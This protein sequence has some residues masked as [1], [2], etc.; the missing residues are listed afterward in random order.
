MNNRRIVICLDGTWNNTYT[1]EERDDGSKVLKPSNVLKLARA[2]LPYDA[3]D[4][5]H[6]LVYYHTG[7]G[8][9]SEYPG[10]SN[11]LLQFCDKNL[12]GGWGAGFES[13]IE[14]AITF[15]VHNYHAEPQTNQADE[16][17][18]YGFSRGAANARALSQF[19]DWM[20]GIPVQ[21]DAYYIPI[22]LKAYVQSQGKQSVDSVKKA[23]R[24]NAGGKPVTL[25][26]MQKIE[27]TMLGVWDTVMALG[28]KLVNRARRTF[29]SNPQPPTCVKHVYHALAVDENRT[30][31]L[32]EIWQQ[33]APKQTLSQM[34]FPGV[35]SNVGGG[36][37]HD[38]LANCSLKW[39]CEQS[40]KH[41]LKL[42]KKFLG[43]YRA[44]P[45]DTLY[46]SK[47][48]FY[49]IRDW[50][51]LTSGVRAINDY[52]DDAQIELHHSVISRMLS[53][54]AE[55]DNRKNAQKHDRL[56]LYRPQNVLDFLKQQ[57]NPV[58]YC[59]DLWQ[60][61]KGRLPSDTTIEKLK[62][63]FEN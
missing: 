29:H 15:L 9:M 12:G 3:E 36:Y 51:R 27:I 58:Q 48:L 2:V 22:F 33:A 60:R 38:G 57:N 31:F 32:P 52:G 35:H 47:S 43:F 30:D 24:D 16:I 6:Q 53:D 23:I 34:W 7:V 49:V 25:Q 20:G 46:V 63:L 1:E 21:Q 55:I 26:A 59:L 44:Y 5:C 19:I 62:R 56:T 8:G 39:F 61:Q 40:A 18:I 10:L 54:P 37:V 41:G 13:N 14:D 45:Q 4:D 50:I 42:D 11:K 17:Y 28:S